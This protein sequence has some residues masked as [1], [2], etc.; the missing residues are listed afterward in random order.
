MSTPQDARARHRQKKRR[1]KKNQ[2][3]LIRRAQENAAQ[4][5]PKAAKTAT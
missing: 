3:W 1:A 2:E 5:A 4:D